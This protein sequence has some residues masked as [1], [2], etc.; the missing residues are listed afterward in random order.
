[1]VI[2]RVGLLPTYE[3]PAE[4]RAFATCKADAF[5]AP[6]AFI[7]IEFWTKG[8]NELSLLELA[9]AAAYRKVDREDLAAFVE[10][11]KR[12]QRLDHLLKGICPKFRTMRA[13]RRCFETERRDWPKN[14]SAWRESLLNQ[15]KDDAGLLRILAEEKCRKEKDAGSSA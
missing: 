11:G 10:G 4:S 14:R 1:V 2:I 13:F 8:T 15:F 6:L 12:Y 9:L 3:T 5:A 7:P